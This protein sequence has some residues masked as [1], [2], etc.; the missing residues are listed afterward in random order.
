ME[1]LRRQSLSSRRRTF[2]P[3]PGR[4]G[5]RYLGGAVDM[6]GFGRRGVEV[7]CGSREHVHLTNRRL[8]CHRRIHRSL[9]WLYVRTRLDSYV[10]VSI[11]ASLNV[12]FR[13]VA[14]SL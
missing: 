10:L 12:F 1:G 13:S 4:I 6:F 7:L 2:R 11:S 5:C 14:S 3:E 9:P 8:V